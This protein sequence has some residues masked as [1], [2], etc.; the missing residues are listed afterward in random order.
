MQTNTFERLWNR[1]GG[2]FDE[3]AVIAVGRFWWTRDVEG[4]LDRI[5]TERGDVS[6]RS[7][8]D[9]PAARRDGPT[10]RLEKAR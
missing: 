8:P 7:C 3:A 9:R 4:L 10:R 2:L 1:V 6:T 5:D